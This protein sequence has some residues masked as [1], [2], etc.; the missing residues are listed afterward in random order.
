MGQT[1][2]LTATDGFRLSAY[3]A[4]P[5][6]TPCGGVVILQEIFGLTSHIR[7]VV[8]QYAAAGYRAIAPA[9]FDRITPDSVFSYEDPLPGRDMVAGLVNA[10]VMADISA[11]VDGVRCGEGVA[12]IGYCW[13]GTLS[14]LAASELEIDAA[15]AYYGTRIAENLD[16]RPNCP[17][18]F[19]FGRHDKLVSMADVGR[20][21]AANP[22]ASS[23][24]Y[25]AGHGFNCDE[26]A[27]HDATSAS[28]ALERTLGFLAEV[29]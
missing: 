10:C 9:L 22:G 24:V 17:F 28:L 23:H 19:H 13:G 4:E 6:E 8:D 29:L 26:R 12:V 14:Y 20:I 15:A 5:G 7:R 16:K 21:L 25:D 27:S 2:N 18:L 3:A 11:A 1:V